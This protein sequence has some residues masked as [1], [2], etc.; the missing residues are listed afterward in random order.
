M[1]TPEGVPILVV[2][3]A[4]QVRDG[5]DASL[6]AVGR[7]QASATAGALNLAGTDRL[8]SS[9]L[10]RAVETATALGRAPERF[11][12]LN[13]FRFGPQWSWAQGN[14]REDLALWRPEHR[15]PGGESLYEFQ[16]RVNEALR[17]Y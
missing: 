13:E 16:E 10:L 14:D 8:V 2:R 5:P 4:Q 7:S 12:A 6:T 15:P 11:A 9:T 3:H 1:A 17:R